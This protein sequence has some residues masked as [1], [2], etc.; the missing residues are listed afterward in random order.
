M[1]SRAITVAALA[2][3]LGGCA[4]DTT[5]PDA[6][7][8]PPSTEHD[9]VGAS[10][11][12]SA[13]ADGALLEAPARVDCTLSDGSPAICV[14]YV[15]G[16][17]P[18]TATLGP[19]CPRNV[20]DGPEVSGIWLEGG[21]V[22]D[23]DGEFIQN[24][25][26]FYNDLQFQL[27]D[28]ATGRINVTDTETA[29]EAAARP[30][31]DARYRNH[32]VECEISY[33]PDD[34]VQVFVI[35]ETPR[36]LGRV[37]AMGR[38]PVGLSFRGVRYDAPAPTDAILS[39]HTLAP[40][41]DCGGHVN[42]A[43]GYHQHAVTDCE[44]GRPSAGGHGAAIGVAL[45][46]FAIHEPLVDTTGLDACFGHQDANGTYHYHAGPGGGNAILGCFTGAYGCA[47]ADRASQCDATQ[48]ARR[49]PPPGEM[50]GDRPPRPP[51]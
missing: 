2:I 11:A 32:C 13:F 17:A 22:Y 26:S 47:L 38:N 46:G 27:F 43:V 10:F 36:R 6:P 7:T 39:A 44:V 49:G 1:M 21:R 19:W 9:P 12:A 14:R 25:A 48:S 35:P 41:D 45:D 37:V 18:R 20:S 5:L 16:A 4:V 30:D 8:P 51:R 40:F 31:V 3:S 29:C 15:V 50:R 23:A 28:P 33:L 34:H 42:T 24:L